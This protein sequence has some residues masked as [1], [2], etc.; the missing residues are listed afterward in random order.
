MFRYP[1]DDDLVKDD[2][3]TMKFIATEN[4]FDKNIVDLLF[5]FNMCLV[6]HQED[7][8]RWFDEQTQRKTL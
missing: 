5:Y 6:V 7:G 3:Q 2:I 8:G 1:L 4:G